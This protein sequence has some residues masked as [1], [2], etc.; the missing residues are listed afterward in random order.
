MKVYFISLGCPKNLT[1]TEV[2]MGQFVNQGDQIT[3]NPKQA[4][5]IVINT[6][7][8]IKSAR[9][10]AYAVI[11]EMKQYKK[12]I[13]LAGCLPK[14][15]EGNNGKSTVE[16]R[17]QI[18]GIDGYIDSIG[19]F[20]CNEPRIKATP[21]WYAYVKIS[22][23]CNN[24]CSYCLI[25]SIRGKLKTRP[26][27][28]VVYEVKQLAKRGVKEVI[29]IAQDTTAHPKLVEILRKSAKIKGIRWLRIMY[30][31]PKHINDKLLDLMAKERKIVKYLDLPIQHYCDKILCRMNRPERTGQGLENLILKIRRKIPKIAIRTSVIVGFPG[32]TKTDFRKL[33]DFLNRVKLD[34]VG[35]FTYFKEKGTLAAKLSQQVPEKTKKQRL[36]A[37]MQL[38]RRISKE[39]NKSM[40]GKILEAIIEGKDR[41]RSYRD[42]PE[43]DSKVFIN[44]QKHLSP[45]EIVKIRI[46]KGG[47]YDL[48]GDIL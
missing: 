37:L 18:V 15:V 22:E 6:C 46:T 31:H 34:H 36:V 28:D 39:K 24:C 11:K 5:I 43:I 48:Y 13:Y 9:D 27:N 44:G 16:N 2:L 47:N 26:V 8:F 3:T 33:Y 42:A 17:E 1:D 45:G 30:S 20:D 7:A 25:P 40:T 41:A 38:C 21:P 32:E 23:G 4:D 19:V 29:F 12:K 14:W 35:V 10:E